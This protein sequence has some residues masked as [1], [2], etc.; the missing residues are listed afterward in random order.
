MSNYSVDCLLGCEDLKSGYRQR[1][2]AKVL[3]WQVRSSIEFPSILR[4]I[5]LPNVVDFHWIST[6]LRTC[7]SHDFRLNQPHTRLSLWSDFSD[8]INC[9]SYPTQFHLCG[10][11]R[12]CFFLSAQSLVPAQRPFHQSAR[13]PETLA[14]SLHCQELGVVCNSRKTSF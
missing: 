11:I 7:F 8:G 4:S 9:C 13:Q 1:E 3:A 10:L 6:T 2:I 12:L 5:P 14:S